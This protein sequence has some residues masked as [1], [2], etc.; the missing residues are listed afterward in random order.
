MDWDQNITVALFVGYTVG[1]NDQYTVF[2]IPL[3]NWSVS[4]AW[5]YGSGFPYTPYY[6]QQTLSNLYLVNTGD[7]PYSSRVDLSLS[8]GFRIVSGLS[9]GVNLSVRNL[10][11]W[12]NVNMIGGG[13]NTLT[14]RVTEYGDYAPSDLV[15]YPWVAGGTAFDA[16]V[17]PYVFD[18]PRHI[19]LGLKLNWD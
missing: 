2:G 5:N 8:K 13:F 12:R 14:G 15:I 1:P 19:I 18:P 17:P 6:R 7:G 16:R 11:D 3:N 4:A 9:L 10:L